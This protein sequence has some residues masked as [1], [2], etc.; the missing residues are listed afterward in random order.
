MKTLGLILLFISYYFYG[1]SQVN[2]TAGLVTYHPFNGNTNDASGNAINGTPYNASLTEDRAGNANNAYYFN[3]NNSYIELPFSNLYNFSPSGSFTISLWVLPDQGYSW[4]AQALVVKLPPNPNF[5]ASQWN[6]GTYLFN[7]NAMGGFGG[8]N[9]VV[10]ATTLSSTKCWYNI[11]Q[12][13]DNGN[14][15]MY[16]NGVLES[17]DLTQTRFILQDGFSKIFFG[18]KGESDGDYYKGKMDDIRIYNRIVTSDEIDAL[19]NENNPCRIT[20][21]VCSGSLGTP[22]V[23][24]TFGSGSTNPGPQLSTL[25]PGA[26]TNYNF[27]AY[28]TGNPPQAIIDGDYALVSAVPVNSAWFTGATDHTGN[29]DGYMAFFNSALTPGEFYRQTVSGL[30]PGTTYEFSTWISNVIDP[31]ELPNAILPNVTFKILNP[32]NSAVLAN[33][34]TGNIPMTST[35]TWKQFSFLFLTPASIS[36]VVLILENN[37]I[38]GNAQPGND[39]A[40]DDITFRPCGPTV[41]ATLNSNSSCTGQSVNLSGSLSGNLNNPSFQWQISA[42]GGSTFA[43]ITG[44]TVANY[45]LSGLPSGNYKIQ[46]L[47]AEGA[48][49]NSSSCRFISN[50]LDLTINLLPPVPSFT[51]TQPT[52]TATSGNIIVNFPTGVGYEYS[53]NGTIYQSSNSFTN[54]SQGNYSL[55]VR[56]SPGGCISSGSSFTINSAPPV[57][58]APAI[59]PLN[60]PTCNTSTGSFIINAPTGAN[61]EYSIDGSIYQTAT[62]F[63]NLQPGNYSVTVRN[64]TNGCISSATSVTINN[65]PAPPQVP[66]SN[67]THPTCITSTGNIQIKSPIGNHFQYS[68]NGSAYQSSNQ[69]TGLPPTTYL[70]R[71]RDNIT[72]CESA[73]ATVTINNIPV[74]PAAPVIGNTVHPT[75]SAPLGRLEI[76]SPSGTNF[77]YS[78]NGINFQSSSSFTGITS[79]SYNAVV[80]DTVTKCTSEATVFII[81]NLPDPPQPPVAEVTQQPSCINATGTLEI[82]EP[83]GSNFEYSL[84]GISYQ[85]SPIFNNLDTGVYPITVRDRLTGCTSVIT[86]ISI[87]TDVSVKSG[88]YIPNAFTPN[89][90]GLN[91]CFGISDWGLITELNFMIFNRWG[92]LVFSTNKPSICWDGNFKKQPALPDNY[93]FYIKA[94]TICG[95]VERKGNIQLIR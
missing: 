62:S 87:S 11:V 28:A 5:L 10:G 90:D 9:V 92:E 6:Y 70:V 58:S 83:V 46:L 23:N 76:L 56:S 4:P 44:A 34:N 32:A 64:S 17:S 12:T 24:I 80:T 82:N 25:V 60:Q 43:N 55:S 86:D 53:I 18:K 3:S 52:C 95:V 61:L 48:N 35:F 84:N 38:G 19:Y 47:A 16:V 50:V 74:P 36:S 51:I 37:N 13:Y 91:D 49:I 85:S 57:P 68:I 45:E 75:C 77:Q 94:K 89:G 30:C 67:V 27:A 73:A 7:Y 66:V 78:I 42:D 1:F 21:Q 8:N 79:G 14:W 72:L 65:T 15:N 29:T 71:V 20:K 54:L 69:F 41:T 22:I 59:A 40:L 26:T 33:F 88:Y 63:T 39:L 81:N 31:S 2:L 93:V